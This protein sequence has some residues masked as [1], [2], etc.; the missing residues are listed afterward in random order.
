M[1]YVLRTIEVLRASW[2]FLQLTFQWGMEKREKILC[3][4]ATKNIFRALANYSFDQ[5][6]VKCP[7][8]YV[9]ATRVIAIVTAVGWPFG[10]TL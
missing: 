1:Y 4:A 6:C 9:L 3:L 5:P 10:F 2:S 7:A 8:Q